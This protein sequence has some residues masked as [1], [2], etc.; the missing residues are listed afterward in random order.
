MKISRTVIILSVVSLLADIASEL[1]YPVMPLF[2]KATGYSFLAIGLLE[3][4]ANLTAGLTKGYFGNLSDQSGARAP[5][6]RTGYGLSSLGKGLLLFSSSLPI[7]YLSRLTDRVGKGV[8]TAPRDAILARESTEENRAAIFGFHRA[9]DTAGAAIGPIL[10]L[11]WL[12]FHPGDYRSLFVIAVL[13]AV[14]SW[15]FTFLI[16]DVAKSPAAT[17][18]KPGFFHYLSYWKTAAVSYRKLMTALIVFALVNSP[19]VFLLLAVKAAGWSDQAMI[20]AYIFYNLIYAL[21]AYPVGK[22]A[23]K[24]GRR[25]VLLGGLFLFMLTYAGMA[26]NQNIIGFFIL[27]LIYAGSMACTESVVKA[28]VSVIAPEKERGTA[29]GFYASVSSIAALVAGAWTGIVFEK[30]GIETAFL[31]TAIGAGFALGWLFYQGKNSI[32]TS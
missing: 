13:P 29:L 17:T 30:Y 2:L 31:L 21:L 6:V 23:D 10:A 15:L 12:W 5:F 8:R 24:I 19:D 3:G 4:L 27:F 28:M 16:K 1:L 9:M 20:G 22:L 25:K 7:I 14:S 18:K 26:F 32:V 11:I